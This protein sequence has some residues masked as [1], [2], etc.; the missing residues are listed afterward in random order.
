MFFL[1]TIGDLAECFECDSI[2]IKVGVIGWGLGIIG[3]VVSFLS[4]GLFGK[5]WFDYIL[6][7]E[8]VVQA[9]QV[10]IIVCSIKKN[11][12]I[13]IVFSS[14]VYLVGSAAIVLLALPLAAIA[15]C[16][17]IAL[18]VICF[19]PKGVDVAVSANASE[20]S[21]TSPQQDDEYNQVIK[22][23]GVFGSD[24]K[25]KDSGFTSLQDE[26]GNIWDRNDDG[27]YSKR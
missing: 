15:T 27:S 17:A 19:L 18:V 10:I 4:Y 24:I 25:A 3:L 20:N 13:G 14:V 8:L 2:N 22:N 5:N 21:E 1:R 23:G 16:V 26:N 7:F 11:K 9:I 12:A 6:W